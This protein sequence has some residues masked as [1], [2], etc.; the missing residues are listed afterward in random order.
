M[1]EFE[2]L[3]QE[4]IDDLREV[5]NIGTGNAASRLSAMIHRRC[6]CNIPQVDTMG[7][8]DIGGVM[9]MGD[10]FVVALHVRVT[11]EVPAVMLVIMKRIYAQ[12]LVKYITKS[13][14]DATG[15]DFTFTAQF[16]LRQVGELISKAFM[17]S[18]NQFLKTKAKYAV[19]EIIS[20]S[21]SAALHAILQRVE[22]KREDSLFIH[23]DFFD[24]EKTFQGKIIY[25]LTRPSSDI[26]LER[27]KSLVIAA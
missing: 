15:K 20:D 9:N 26:I 23:T 22:T 21:W 6:L 14:L 18:V 25:I 8:K 12:L 3:T 1:P 11:G 19:A 13:A 5:G 10:S 7:L 24:P 16:A 27:T 2:K 17:D 4:Q